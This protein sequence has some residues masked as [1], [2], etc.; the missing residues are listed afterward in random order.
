MRRRWKWWLIFLI[1]SPEG[2]FIQSNWHKFSIFLIVHH[3]GLFTIT[4]QYKIESHHTFLSGTTV[5]LH[6]LSRRGGTSSCL[7]ER[8]GSSLDFWSVVWNP[9]HRLILS[10]EYRKVY[11][12]S[13]MKFCEL[14]I[15]DCILVFKQSAYVLCL[16]RWLKKWSYGQFKWPLVVWIW[17]QVSSY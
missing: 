12:F 14:I 6:Y 2:K 1:R 13:A 4:F 10:W 15:N 9:W 11:Q 3:E 5:C 16:Y 17:D 8:V 7:A